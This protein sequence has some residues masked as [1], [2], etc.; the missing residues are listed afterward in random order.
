[1]H[2]ITGGMN[3]QKR[4]AITQEWREDPDACVLAFSNVATT[5]LNMTEAS[6]V[7][8]FVSVQSATLMDHSHSSFIART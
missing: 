1:M 7:I 6:I 5:G 8:H 4:G 2:C 3:A